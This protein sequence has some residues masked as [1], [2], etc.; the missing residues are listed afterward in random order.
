MGLKQKKL[1]IVVKDGP[2]F[3]TVRALAP[4]LAE[5]VRLMQEG[6]SPRDLDKITTD[7]GWPVGSAALADEVGIDV[8]LHV[9]EFLSAPPPMRNLNSRNFRP[10]VIKRDAHLGGALGPRMGGA[11]IGVLKEMVQLGFH[12]E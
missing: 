10:G 12:G 4:M 7:F 6:V 2:G 1:V 3:Y 11:D 8:A 9:S 5:A